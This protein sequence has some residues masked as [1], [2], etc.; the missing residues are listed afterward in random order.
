MIYPPIRCEV[1]TG[2]N[3]YH[4][5]SCPH[6]INPPIDKD[7]IEAKKLAAPVRISEDRFVV[8]NPNNSF[9]MAQVA[10]LLPEKYRC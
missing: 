7:A 9:H 10:L 3:G 8:F 5:Q 1:C 2:R 4:W 6:R